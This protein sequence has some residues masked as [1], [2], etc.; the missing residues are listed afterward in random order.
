[1]MGCWLRMTTDGH[2]HALN[3][4]SFN[5]VRPMNRRQFQLHAGRRCRK[6][7]ITSVACL[8]W[9]HSALTSNK[10][11]DLVPEFKHTTRD[12][13]SHNDA[14]NPEVAQQPCMFACTLKDYWTHPHTS[15]M[16][17]QPARRRVLR[18][19]R[20]FCDCEQQQ[21]VGHVNPCGSL[22]Q[23]MIVPFTPWSI[24]HNIASGWATRYPLHSS[25][26]GIDHTHNCA[27]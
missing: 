4:P 21:T 6:T 11:L 14:R 27:Y 19:A 26:D 3:A 10:L 5:I 8:L 13:H 16:S 24:H 22:D 18:S 2:K 23:A 15:L 17:P 12:E 1:M 20:P 25:T 7:A 9:H